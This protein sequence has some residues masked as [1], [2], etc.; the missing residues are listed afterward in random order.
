MSAPRRIEITGSEHV[1]RAR[2][3]AREAMA[4]RS[5]VSQAA[6]ELVASELVTNALLHGGGCAALEVVPLADGIRLEVTDNNQRAPLVA[7][8]STDTMTGRGLHMVGRLAARWGIEPTDDGKTVWAEIVDDPVTIAEQTDNELVEA[9]AEPAE[10]GTRVEQIRINLGRV[11]TSL[12]VAAKAHVDNL[13]REFALASAGEEAGTTAPVPTDL[14]KLIE[15][16][17]HGFEGAR[18]QMKRQAVDAA[19]AG[20]SHT[21]LVLDLPADAAT[22]AEEY[23]NA[24]DEVDGYSRANRLLTLETPPQHRVFRRWYVGEVIKQLRAAARGGE[25]PDVVPFEQRLLDEMDEAEQARRTAEQAARL[26]TVAVALAAADTPEAVAAAVLQEGVAAL[27]ASGGGILL[28]ADDES[29]SVPGTFGYDDAIVQ[30]LRQEP[31]NAE[32]PAAYALRMGEPVWLETVDERDERFPALAGFEPHTVAMCAVPLTTPEETLGAMRFSFSE[33]RL[34]DEDEQRFVLALAAE[35]SQA[36]QR[37]RVSAMLQQSLLPAALPDIA[38]TELGACYA[39]AGAAVGGDFYDVFSLGEHR[40]GITLGDVRGRGPRAAALTALTR[41]TVRTAARMQRSPADVLAILNDAMA[42]EGDIEEFCT[43]VFAVLDCE[44]PSRL[45]LA[46]GGHP[47]VAL[48]RNGEATLLPPTGGLLGV[49]PDAQFHEVPLALE[50]G[51][52]VVFYTDG[53]S[54]ARRG[55]EEFGDE[56]LIATLA[57]LHGSTA[58]EVAD[59]LIASAGAFRDGDADDDAAA[60]VF[61]ILDV[62]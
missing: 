37:A 56:Q 32:L 15:R 40:W 43:T 49:L 9:W 44:H 1:G 52:L 26:Y 48:V 45:T 41:Y 34:F 27:R 57:K 6:A 5:D 7:L 24:L 10:A 25:R 8:A 54:E 29:L 42:A 38:G 36:L 18:F 60:F 16:V 31:R 59:G 23:L 46:N 14:A 33:R 47:P 30:R 61:R 50:A 11:P 13:V 62:R 2:R 58:Q 28:A 20:K 4:G 35:T 55:A 3:L 12:L 17:V 39:A 19:R 53:V 22:T 21:T 51:D